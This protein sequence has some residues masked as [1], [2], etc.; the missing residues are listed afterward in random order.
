MIS[1]VTVVFA[2]NTAPLVVS[3]R[4]CLVSAFKQLVI[5]YTQEPTAR[6]AEI[7]YSSVTGKRL[8]SIADR[9]TSAMAIVSAAGTALAVISALAGVMSAR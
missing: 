7:V 2:A 1:A 6:I 9:V 5:S 3:A 4:A 8:T